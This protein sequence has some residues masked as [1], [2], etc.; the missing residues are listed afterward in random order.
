M[1]RSI[2]FATI[3]FLTASE[4][5]S[6]V[7]F[8]W[9]RR[10]ST[11][12]DDYAKIV[13]TDAAGNIYV[14][15]T[16]RIF[17]SQ[18]NYVVIK[19]NSAG[20]QLWATTYNHPANQD[21]RMM[22]MVL[23]ASGNVYV[24]GWS[25]VNTSTGSTSEAVTLKI[26]SSG[27]LLWASSYAQPNGWPASAEAISIDGS[28]NVFITGYSLTGPFEYD[29]LTI[30][31][32]SS[33]VQQW[34]RT[35]NGSAGLV[36]W[37]HCIATDAA[38]NVYVT[39]HSDGQ[40]YKRLGFSTVIIRTF[41][42]YLTIKYDTNGNEL[43]QR[44]YNV[45]NGNDVPHSMKVT[46]DGTVYIT[47]EG[48]GD[49][50]TLK[51]NSAGTLQWAHNYYGSAG[52]DVGNAIVVDGTGAVFVAGM[53]T[54]N[55]TDYVTIKYNSS[56]TVQWARYY[57]SPGNGYD[58]ASAMSGDGYGNVYV[59]GRAADNFYTIKYN[60]SGTQLWAVSYNA[61]YVDEGVSVSVYESSGPTYVPPVIYVAGNSQASG[62]GHDIALVKYTQPIV[63]GK[64]AVESGGTPLNGESL[65]VF[66]NPF[67]KSTKV[68]YSISEACN[69]SLDVIDLSGKRVANI[70]TGKRLAGN[71]VETFSGSTLASGSYTIRLTRQNGRT[72]RQ[73]TVTV[74]K[75]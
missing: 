13:K 44:T 51:Y 29:F 71:Y 3:L 48:N 26:S 65:S 32:N 55:Q 49:M 25:R 18:G 64:Q 53:V 17:S 5:I 21:D 2:L 37:A 6:Q 40:I 74:I 62:T 38:G 23:D 72:A 46:P 45:S 56:G 54:S 60:T 30:K 20:T 8:Q 12:S 16:S 28:G 7:S 57:N 42:D 19:Y 11:T 10:Y 4:S 27:A 34:L 33:G 39:G 52:R 59:T 68:S 58:V 70:F 14:A 35:K 43:W 66:P 67:N 47:G 1:L 50:L 15:G 22:D 9:A 63:L 73:Q 69:A 36:D 75:K 61:G 24:A 41:Y 31:Y